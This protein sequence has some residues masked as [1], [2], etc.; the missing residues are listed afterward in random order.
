MQSKSELLCPLDGYSHYGKQD[1]GSFLK[2]LKAELPYDPVLALL[3]IYPKVLGTG[4]WRWYLGIGYP[5][6]HGI[7]VSN[8]GYP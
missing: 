2:K 6:V 7:W 1:V 5:N 4:T 3:G 8:V